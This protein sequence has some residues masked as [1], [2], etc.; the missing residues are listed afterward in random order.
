MMAIGV[1]ASVVCLVY[2]WVIF[3]VF[4]VLRHRMML[5]GAVFLLIRR[6]GLSNLCRKREEPRI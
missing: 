1:L 5:V 2:L 3:V 6:H 4:K